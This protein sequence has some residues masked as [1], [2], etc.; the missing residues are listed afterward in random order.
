[1]RDPA[2]DLGDDALA[3]VEGET[4]GTDADAG[5]YLEQ[6]DEADP[7]PSEEAMKAAMGGGKSDEE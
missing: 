6:S 7:V 4:H 5:A 1:M 2:D 3:A